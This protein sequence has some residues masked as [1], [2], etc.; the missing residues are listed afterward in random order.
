MS[1]EF[2]MFRIKRRLNY[3]TVVL[4][5]EIPHCLEHSEKN[6]VLLFYSE[7]RRVPLSSTANVAK[8]REA[9]IVCLNLSRCY[10]LFLTK[11][12]WSAAS[13]SQGEH[14][15]NRRQ[16]NFKKILT[17]ILKITIIWSRPVSSGSGMYLK[18]VIVV[19]QRVSVVHN[20]SWLNRRLGHPLL[21]KAIPGLHY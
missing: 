17:Q 8:Y 14:L 2:F 7:N 11:C 15:I 3:F 1:F 10:L 18:D 16:E 9:H 6:T 4:G 19:W 13:D 5:S 12:Q 20:N 21:F